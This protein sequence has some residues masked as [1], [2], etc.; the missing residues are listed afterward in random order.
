MIIAKNDNLPNIRRKYKGKKIV[1]CSGTFDLTH[2]G[3][4]LFF[5]D[6]KKL[7]NIL[8]VTVGSDEAIKKNKGDQR[9]ILNEKTRLKMISSLKPVNYC[10]LEKN[11]NKHPLSH[12]DLTLKHLRPDIYVINNDAFNVPYRKKIAKKYN[13]K[14]VILNRWCPPEFNDISTTNIIE[15]IRNI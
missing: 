1:F 14:L 7:G 13:V 5:E 12:L 3:H 11:T 2:V 9:P 8:V 15:K 4:V 10:L 6:C